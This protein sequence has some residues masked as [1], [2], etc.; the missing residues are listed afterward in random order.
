MRSLPPEIPPENKTLNIVGAP[1]DAG[2]W[3]IRV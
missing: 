3:A 1:E 2:S